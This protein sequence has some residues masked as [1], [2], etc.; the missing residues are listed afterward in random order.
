MSEQQE[1]QFALQRI[2]IKDV[3]FESP[4]GVD[5]FTQQ[6]QPQIHQELSTS[7]QR[8]EENLYEVALTVTVT[9]K[10]DDKT[11]FLVEV[12][13]AGVFA[14]AGFD[15]G[16]LRQVMGIH[17]PNILFP[18]ARQ[19]VD[20]LM[21]AGTLP[22]L[23]LPAVNFEALFQQAMAQQQQQQPQAAH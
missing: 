20:N 7:T 4:Q 22:P 5:A 3:S 6:W 8:L 2:Y 11:V 9:G 10:I 13:Q 17:C 14:L 18:Y 23:H 19:M 15:E 21:V 1:Q 12:K 16:Q